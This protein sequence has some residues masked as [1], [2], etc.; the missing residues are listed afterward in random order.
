MSI[1]PLYVV[2]ALLCACQ[3]ASH[4]EARQI[5]PSLK[6][7]P[8][9]DQAA[10]LVV[11]QAWSRAMPPGSTVGA[12]YFTLN[13][14]GP[15]AR[16]LT[17]VSTPVAAAAELHRTLVEDGMSKMRPAGIIEIAP[18][19]TLSAEPGG[20]H[21]MLRDLKQP[22]VAGTTIPL[23]LAFRDIAPLHVQVAVQAATA[24]AHDSHTGH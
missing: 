7:N 18:G 1:R 5:A 14:P 24:S 20:L 19:A 15:E 6:T 4:E 23:E 9:A 12:V 13:N 8:P 17:A 3:P 2:V 16:F 10:R 11:T 21:V 22:L